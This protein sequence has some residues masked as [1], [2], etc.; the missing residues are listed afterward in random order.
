M[1]LW[2]AAQLSIWPLTFIE[3]CSGYLT[4]TNQQEIEHHQLTSRSHIK[5]VNDI[6]ASI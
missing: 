2:V 4:I 1:E 3:N 5:E 6:S